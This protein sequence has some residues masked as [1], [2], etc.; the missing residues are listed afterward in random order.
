MTIT[1]DLVD[2][3]PKIAVPVAVGIGFALF[4]KYLPASRKQAQSQASGDIAEHFTGTYVLVNGC[5]IVIGLALG[6]SVYKLLV[7][8]NLWFAELDSP[9]RFQLLPTK[10]IWWFLPGFGALCLSWE[11][12]LTLWSLF[13]DRERIARFVEWTH[14]RA[15]YNCTRALRWLA[16]II[17]LPVAIVTLPAVPMHATLRDDGLRIRGYATW[18]ARS[19][20][21]SQA[22]RVSVVQGNRDRKGRFIQRATVIVQ[23]DDGFVW[24]SA[25]NRDFTSKPDSGLAEFLGEK[26]G[27]EITYAETASDIPQSIRPR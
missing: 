22:C 20:Q 13:G 4:R 11:I 18:K 25:D 27:L 21:Y 6:F 23:F 12:T 19:Y 3:L 2:A 5:L 16:L 14:A 17:V 1:S 9:S 24:D 15:G 8:T 10:A 26:T 7:S